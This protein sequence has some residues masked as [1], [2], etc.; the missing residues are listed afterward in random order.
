MNFKASVF[1]ILVLFPCLIIAQAPDRTKFSAAE[2]KQDLAY[3][4]ET[5]QKSHYNLFVNTPKTEFDQALQ[6]V[7]TGIT[8]SLTKLEITRIFQSF[9][10]LSKL[11]HCSINFPSN[12]YFDSV[13]LNTA[14]LFPFTLTVVDKKAIITA[15]FSSDSSIRAGAELV[16]INNQAVD[17]WLS[18]IHRFLSGETE[19][20]RNSLM[21]LISFP[22]VLWWN[23]GNRAEF[24]I[25]YSQEGVLKKSTVPAL[26]AS[27]L[28]KQLAMQKSVFS[29]NREFRILNN[30]I[31][32]LHPGIFLNNESS[33]NT[34][35]HNTFKKNE[36][37][38]FIDS[39]FLAIHD[40]KSKDLIID[41]RGNPGGDNS[42]SDHM[43]AYFATKPFWFCS[44][45]NVK[46]SELTKR[47][48]K[49][50]SDPSVSELKT[51]IL[52]RKD[53]EVFKVRFN[54]YAPRKDSLRFNG[55]V[56]VL[57]DRYSYSNTVA[58]AAIVQ[59]YRFGTVMGEPTA[60]VASTYGAMHSII[61][62]I[63]G[64]D[65]GYPKAFIVRPNGDKSLRGV[66]PDIKAPDDIFTED[67]EVLEQAVAYIISRR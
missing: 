50:V 27:E 54:K 21:E 60:D 57:I 58:V 45:F 33:G 65:V 44:E 23:Y 16:S 41:L 28:E 55:R 20:L 32:Y 47:F 25:G 15:N 51:E 19:E 61:L 34:S 13:N 9:V 7:N 66:S 31:A 10:A 6:K 2:V 52:R 14:M 8:D 22:R 39:A 38:S 12:L 30:G 63:T 56:C 26:R 18:G 40:A 48:W 67:D 43:I 11:A 4:Y 37:V 64:I 17:A 53:G 36:F 1:S 49:D 59:D 5:L 24:T 3:L 62:P 46:T 35:E 42:F 29:T